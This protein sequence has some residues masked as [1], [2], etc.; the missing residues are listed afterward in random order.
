MRPR[1]KDTETSTL[2]SELSE[3]SPLKQKKKGRRKIRQTEEFHQTFNQT[4]TSDTS[5]KEVNQKT[6]KS[7]K[8]V[9]LPQ[10]DNVAID[11]ELIEA[12]TKSAMSEHE[13]IPKKRGRKKKKRSSDKENLANAGNIY[14]KFC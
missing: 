13:N 6:K 3:A 10:I 4:L 5:P 9:L 8:L 12:T 2:E 14:S 7:S 1:R 11:N